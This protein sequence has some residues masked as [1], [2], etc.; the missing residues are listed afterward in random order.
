VEDLFLAARNQVLGVEAYIDEF[1]ND[2]FTGEKPKLSKSK[3][4]VP[5]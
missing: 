3:N 5:Y 1:L 2:D 4:D